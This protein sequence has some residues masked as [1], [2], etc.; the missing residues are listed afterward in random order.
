MVTV[1][2]PPNG[3]P[4]AALREAAAA[5]PLGQPPPAA[6]PVSSGLRRRPAGILD[7]PASQRRPHRAPSPVARE[8][9]GV[10][11]QPGWVPAVEALSTWHGV[12]ERGNSTAMCVVPGQEKEQGVIK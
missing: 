8:E 7:P 2:R 6:R 1:S 5:P 4:R 11:P 3:R 10:G 9:N 12:R